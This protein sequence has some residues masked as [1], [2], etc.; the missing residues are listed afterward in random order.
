MAEDQFGNIGPERFKEIQK[1]AADAARGIRDIGRE[2]N[3][4]GDATE[5]SFTKQ[6]NL[7]RDLA[8]ITASTLKN[9]REV[10][11]VERRAR[12]ARED[13]VKAANRLSEINN[14]LAA[15]AGR[16]GAAAEEQRKLLYRQ[17]Q[18]TS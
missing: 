6:V 17:L 10:A 5:I 1:M 4:T 9:K 7:A 18:I 11:S 16:Q 2:I 15:L 14:N 12:Q 3:A 8:G 13:E